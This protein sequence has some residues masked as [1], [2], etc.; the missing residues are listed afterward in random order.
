MSEKKK[1][2]DRRENDTCYF[3]KLTII[4][5]FHGFLQ[6]AEVCENFLLM[7]EEDPC[8]CQRHVIFFH[9]ET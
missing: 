4:P 3:Y 8:C 6:E 5:V 7:D 9:V 2:R 1:E